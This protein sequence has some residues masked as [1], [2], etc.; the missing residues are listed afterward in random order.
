MPERALGSGSGGE[1]WDQARLPDIGRDHVSLNRA[2]VGVGN[3]E[4]EWPPNST[5]ELRIGS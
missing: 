3:E 5:I 1:I 4:K 2:D